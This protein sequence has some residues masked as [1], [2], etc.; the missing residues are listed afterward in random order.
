M[1]AAAVKARPM[2]VARMRK[3]FQQAAAIKRWTLEPGNWYAPPPRAGAQRLL[4]AFTAKPVAPAAWSDRL[5]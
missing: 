4:P 1:G 2:L 3:A 5:E